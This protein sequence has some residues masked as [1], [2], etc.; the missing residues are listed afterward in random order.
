MVS[1]WTSI[2]SEFICTTTSELN[3][4][5][6]VIRCHE[7][8]GLFVLGDEGNPTFLDPVLKIISHVCPTSLSVAVTAPVFLSSNPGV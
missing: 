7:W 1:K 2:V 3:K 4:L 5:H 6:V 8:F